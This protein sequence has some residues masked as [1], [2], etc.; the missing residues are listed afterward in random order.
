MIMSFSGYRRGGGGGEL[1]DHTDEC[2]F[3]YIIDDCS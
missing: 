1:E 2:R 3:N